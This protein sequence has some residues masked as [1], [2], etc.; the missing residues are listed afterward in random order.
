MIR[1]A[2]STQPFG[3][4][5]MTTSILLFVLMMA[6]ATN[7][8]RGEAPTVA[9]CDLV[10]NA[11]SYD[12][13]LV[14]VKVT[15]IVGFEA[16]VMYDLACRTKDAWVDFDPVVEPSTDRKI[17]KRFR[18]LANAKPEITRG[19]GI[20]YVERRVEVVWVGRFRGIKPTQTIGNRSYSFGFGHLN[21]FDYQF[22]VQRIGSVRTV[23]AGMPWQ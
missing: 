22:D 23:P 16:S 3:I 2:A 15:Y 1:A 6:G 18:K 4:Y 20:N 14:R 12:Q 21:A 9:Y 11:A 19:G 17:M 10:T 13:K 8:V 5:S 7:Q